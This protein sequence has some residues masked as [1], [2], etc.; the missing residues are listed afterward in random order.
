MHV[1]WHCLR[2]SF[3]VDH[4]EHGFTLEEVAALL[5][6]SVRVTAKHY[7]KWSAG[8][9]SV[10]AQKQLAMYS[11]SEPGFAGLGLAGPGGSSGKVVSISSGRRAAG[12]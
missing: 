7:A 8:R 9:Q 11:Q 6:D 2:D 3:A 5:G 12:A 4:L 10:V 1:H